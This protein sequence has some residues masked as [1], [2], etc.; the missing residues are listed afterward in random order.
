LVPRK[1]ITIQF[2][3]FILTNFLGELQN[4]QRACLDKLCK[5]LWV[6]KRQLAESILHL[7]QCQA[8]V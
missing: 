8:L 5:E 1:V 3:D 4:I 2:R 7:R 6:C